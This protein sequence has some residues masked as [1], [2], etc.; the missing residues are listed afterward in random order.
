[1]DHFEQRSGQSFCE[2]VPLRKIADDVGT[3]V[4]IYSKATIYKHLKRFREA[5]TDYPTVPCFAVKANSHIAILSEVFRAGFGAD[6]VSGGE[7]ARAVKAGVDAKKI[8]F[9]GVGKRPDEI[10]AALENGVLSFNVESSF[11]LAMID[12]IAGA[13]GKV[14]PVCLRVNPNIDA[15][16]NPKIATGLFSTKFGI[17]EDEVKKLAACIKTYKNCELVGIACHIG[18]QI[19]SLGPIGEACEKMVSLA[20]TLQPEHPTLS[21][22]NMG[23][24]L[25]I[26]YEN[27]TTPPIEDY[28]KLLI[29]TIK[30]TGLTLVLEPGRVLLGNAGVLLTKV[31]GVKNSEEKNFAIVDAAMND[32]IRPSLYD[33]YHE[34]VVSDQEG[35]AEKTL[36]DVV[37]PICETGDFFAKNR[38]LPEVKAGDLV[39][40]RACGA[41]AASMASNYNSRPRSAEVL[42][43]DASYRVITKRESMNDLWARESFYEEAG[44]GDH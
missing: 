30:P 13:H 5:F 27:E 1:M 34:I 15:K 4:Y 35:S 7:L 29:E 44:H 23:G 33:S 16:T 3:P 11:E 18:S 28:A 6:L 25:G 31:I 10:E 14:A 9:S 20:Q 40:I 36:Y 24:G 42:V 32:M 12:E 8:V 38:S 21:Y 41:Y 19:T 17:T 26:R 22:L 37:G 43:D 2:S 39:Y